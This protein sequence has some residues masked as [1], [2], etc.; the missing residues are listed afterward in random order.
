M[1]LDIDRRADEPP[2]HRLASSSIQL[3]LL[4]AVTLLAALLRFYKLGAWSFWG[5]EMLSIVQKPDGFNFNLIR[6]SLALSL[7]DWTTDWLGVN[8]WSARLAPALIGVITIP[9]LYLPIRRMAGSTAA[10]IAGLLL[11]LSPWHIYWSQN[12]RFYILLLLFYSLA[13]IAFFLGMEQDRPFYLLLS[14]L[15]L[16]LAARE[17]LLALFLVPVLGGYLVL[18]ALLPLQKPR[19]FRRTRTLALALLPAL[20]LAAYFAWPYIQILPDWFRGFYRIN[21]SPIWIA[22]GV[23]YYIR[24]V[25]VCF[26]AGGAVYLLTHPQHRLRRLGLLLSLSAVLPIVALM[27]LSTFQYAANR[28]VFITLSS[29]IILAAVAAVQLIRHAG[30]N[31]RWL[32]LGALLVLMVD[33]LAENVLYYRYQNGNRDD[34]R[35]AFA[36]VEARSDPQDRIITPHPELADFYLERPTNRYSQADPAEIERAAQTVWFVEDLNVLEL[37]PEFYHWLRNTAEL[38]G[39]FD[40]SVQ[41]RTF[42]MR[43]YR[44]FPQTNVPP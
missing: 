20:F 5:D 25:T 11:A 24:V 43:V 3:T 31:A 39:V 32:A 10:L 22:A 38:V 14:V 9:V 23:T 6:Q 41:A 37:Y 33:P 26:A 27:I 8:E 30:H 29:W 17:R 2:Q 15:F 28:Y 4:I 7:I 35:S 12:A 42:T 16:G 21:N 1:A 18:V 34:W 13:L 40:V 19:G 44:Y 36:L